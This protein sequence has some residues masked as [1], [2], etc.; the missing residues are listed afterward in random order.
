MEMKHANSI[1]QA[2]AHWNEHQ[3]KRYKALLQSGQLA[4]ALRAAA[5]ATA[6]DMDELRPQVGQ[7]SAWEM[8]RER[9]LFPPEEKG[10]SPQAPRSAGCAPQITI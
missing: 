1:A 10:N 7:E 5:E 4:P 9:H 3:P 2:S 6:R 8:V